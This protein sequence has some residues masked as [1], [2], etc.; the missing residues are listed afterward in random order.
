MSR[1]SCDPPP[2]P[3]GEQAASA[4]KL[5]AA[6][7][8]A[9]FVFESDSPELMALVREAFAGLPARRAARRG[10][11]L[12]VKLVLTEPLAHRRGEPPPLQPLSAAG[13]LC[14]V[15][16]GAALMSTAPA[17]RAA[18]VVVP[19]TLIGRRYHVRYE[20]IEFAAYVLAARA[21]RLLPLH[22][23]CVGFGNAGALL[24]GA[25]GAGKS[26]LALASV[27]GGAEFLAE[28]SVLL[29]RSL[30][31][32]GLA[33]FLHA[34]PG[35]LRLF[36]ATPAVRR[37]RRAPLIRRRSGVAKLEIDLRASRWRLAAA[38]LPVRALLFLTPRRAAGS[39]LRPLTPAQALRRLGRSQRYAAAQ[40]G[41]A[42]LL[43]RLARLPAF[44]LR[45]A[46]PA[47]QLAAVRAALAQAAP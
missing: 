9:R 24:L 15:A 7:L 25:S 37:L 46:A 14:G 20:L 1:A 16:N 33:N 12:R 3:F 17:Q 35:T 22:A 19:R 8:G 29:D 38:P 18:L 43:A 21:G 42:G 47:A 6:V 2:D 36:G 30:Q 4:L 44:E 13:V 28:D 23:A 45:R 26:T 31:A 27:L 32:F 34:P 11:P 41:G 39:L 10:R 5:R 40:R